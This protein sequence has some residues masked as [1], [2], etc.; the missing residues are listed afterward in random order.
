MPGRNINSIQVGGDFCVDEA[1]MD[2]YTVTCD[3][4]TNPPPVPTEV[5]IQWLKD[6]Q[7]V[8]SFDPDGNRGISPA[9]FAVGSGNE[10]FNPNNINPGVLTV[11]ASDNLVVRTEAFNVSMMAMGVPMDLSTMQIRQR[12]ANA[13]LG[14]WTCSASNV[15]GSDSESTIIRQCGEVIV[16]I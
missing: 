1:E 12:I 5:R 15:Y 9:F 13:L 14:N 10:V 4:G 8:A 2:R 6:G 3:I 16:I 11:D 7:N